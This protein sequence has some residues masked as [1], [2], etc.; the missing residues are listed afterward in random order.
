MLV[1]RK[2]SGKGCWRVLGDLR[3]WKGGMGGVW[4]RRAGW[5]IRR[6]RGGR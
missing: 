6:G 1:V 2:G 4:G 5:R 3:M